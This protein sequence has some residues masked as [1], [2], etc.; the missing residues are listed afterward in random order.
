MTLQPINSMILDNRAQNVIRLGGFYLLKVLLSEMS[1]QKTDALNGFS[2]FPSFYRNAF[3][4]YNIGKNVIYRWYFVLL[5]KVTLGFRTPVCY[6]YI[7]L[8][9]SFQ[10]SCSLL[11]DSFHLIIEIHSELRFGGKTLI[12][13]GLRISYINFYA[14]SNSA[15]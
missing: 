5:W 4:E 13:G 12:T 10:M 15:S 7:F 2:Q 3:K 11:Y 9:F 8:I 6:K 1:L 14:D